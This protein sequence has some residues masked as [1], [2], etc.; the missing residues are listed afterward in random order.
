MTTTLLHKDIFLDNHTMISRKR[1]WFKCLKTSRMISNIYFAHTFD[2][3]LFHFRFLFFYGRKESKVKLKLTV[4][5]SHYQNN[6]SL[7][8][9]QYSITQLKSSQT[10]VRWGWHMQWTALLT[11]TQVPPLLQGLNWHGLG[12]RA[13]GEH[14]VGPYP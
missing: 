4:Y 5:S 13:V 14:P 10:P 6:K 8:Q 12:S 3:N 9:D 2:N 11:T 7:T 1:I